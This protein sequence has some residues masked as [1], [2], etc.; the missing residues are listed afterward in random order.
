MVTMY[1]KVPCPYC[2]QAERLLTLKGVPYEKID[3]TN[4]HDAIMELADRSGMRTL[5][6][7]FHDD[8]LIGGFDDLAVLEGSQGLDH[9]KS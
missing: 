5:P 2:V 7:I 8:K 1:S 3:L 9:L 4:D 6:Q